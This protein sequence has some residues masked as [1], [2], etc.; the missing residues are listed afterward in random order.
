MNAPKGHN[1][2]LTKAKQLRGLVRTK[3]KKLLKYQVQSKNKKILQL[4]Q[5]EKV[6]NLFTPLLILLTFQSCAFYLPTYLPT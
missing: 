2:Y 4:F 1:T 6:A 3:M 5:G